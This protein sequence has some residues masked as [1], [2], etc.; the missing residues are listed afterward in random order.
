MSKKQP[1][2]NTKPSK[3]PFTVY[4]G[5][6]SSTT[7]GCTKRKRLSDVVNYSLSPDELKSCPKTIEQPMRN[8][9]PVELEIL[10]NAADRSSGKNYLAKRLDQSPREKYYFPEATSWRIGWIQSH[11]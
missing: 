11:S 10:Y 6:K 5:S 1:S 3:K 2:K 7:N 8:A 4:A 9:D